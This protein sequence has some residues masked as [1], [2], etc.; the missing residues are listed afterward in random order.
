M[1]LK[2]LTG[3][4][5]A[6]AVLLTLPSCGALR[7]PRV[8]SVGTRDSV[9]VEVRTE[10]VERVDT[11]LVSVPYESVRNVTPDTLSV[12]ETSVARSEAL[13][14]G[15]RLHHSLETRSGRRIPVPVTV[16]TEVRDSVVWRDREVRVEVPVVTEKPLT[17]WQQ[18]RIRWWWIPWLLALFAYRKEIFKLAAK[19]F[20]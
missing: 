7:C 2:N 15:G 13:V 1:K 11:V 19:L 9:R 17:L 20:V 5:A 16:R 3:L 18:V 4:A 14:C 6:A 10:T 12:L 8:P